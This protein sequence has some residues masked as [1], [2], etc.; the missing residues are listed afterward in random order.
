MK[1]HHLT[2]VQPRIRAV[3]QCNPAGS[4]TTTWLTP[5]YITAALGPFDLDPCTPPN[6]PWR[7][8]TRM[9][10][11]KEDGLA[12]P[13]PTSDFV[14]HNPPYGKG[15][16]QWMAKAANH[17]N[18]FTLIFLR[19]DAKYF[20]Q[21]VL[22]HKNATAFLMFEGRLKF[23][24]GDG[25]ASKTAASPSVLIA[26]GQKAKRQLIQA[27]SDGKLHGRIILLTSAQR[28]VWQLGRKPARVLTKAA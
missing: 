14:W 4:T 13:W 19:A 7:T 10:T 5:Q 1:A 8:A 6:M 11:E 9:L 15:M 28:T 2:P 22:R 20:H 24:D 25:I 18:G 17:G 12:T 23:C 21:S 16:N 27:V 26:Y 3:P